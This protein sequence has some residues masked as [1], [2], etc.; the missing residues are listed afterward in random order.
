LNDEKKKTIILGCLGAVIVTVGAFQIIGGKK[1]PPPPAAA[2]AAA[3]DKKS[4]TAVADTVGAPVVGPDG[5]V[6]PKN[7]EV[8]NDLP[9]R[10]P[11]QPPA[12]AFINL[13]PAPR[14]ARVA[15]NF[16][17][18]IHPLNGG[19]QPFNVVRLPSADVTM[20][21]VPKEDPFRYTLVGSI[22]GDKA[23][24]LL[25]DSTGNQ[26][27]VPVGGAIDGESRLVSIGHGSVTVIV[28]GKVLRLSMGGNPVEK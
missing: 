16:S 25:Q 13:G 10:D 2:P 3:D 27:V 28:R 17:S 1:P 21:P 19:L 11:F 20:P 12:S 8:A 7:P 15:S 6:V 26:K 24:A 18:R 22:A 14:A 4:D 23:A 9:P 5:K